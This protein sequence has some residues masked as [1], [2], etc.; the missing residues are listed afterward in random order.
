[1]SGIVGHVGGKSGVIGELTNPY[2][3]ANTKSQSDISDS[4][5]QENLFLAGF[6]FLGHTSSGQT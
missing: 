1:M 5:I 4:G 2:I 3:N 6:K